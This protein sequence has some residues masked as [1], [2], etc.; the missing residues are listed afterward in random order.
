MLHSRA[1]ISDEGASNYTEN[2]QNTN[3]QGVTGR[4]GFSE[5]FVLF[6]FM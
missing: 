1:P 5:S 4:Q 2:H 6:T 3:T